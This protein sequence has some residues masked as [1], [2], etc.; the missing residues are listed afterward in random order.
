[1]TGQLEGSPPEWLFLA[2]DPEIDRSGGDPVPGLVE[3]ILPTLNWRAHIAILHAERQAGGDRIHGILKKVAGHLREHRYTS[4]TVHPH[5][6]SNAGTGAAEAFPDELR[7]LVQPFREEAYREQSEPRLRVLP[8]LVPTSTAGSG[9]PVH[10]RASHV[11]ETVLSRVEGDP[12]GLLNPCRRHIVLDEKRG[13]LHSCLDAWLKGE[14]GAAD[15]ETLSPPAAGRCAG[16][17]RSSVLAMKDALSKGGRSREVRR[18]CFELGVALSRRGDHGKA[19]SLARGAFQLSRDDR[20]RTAALIHQGLCHL[21]L[22]ELRQAEEVLREADTRAEDPGA[23]AYHRGRVQFAWKDWIEAL[24]RFEEALAAPS[25]EVPVHDIH[26]HMA[27]CH[28]NLEEY[29]EARPHLDLAGD[30]SLE[31][32]VAFYRAICDLNDGRIQEALNGFVEA[33]R[34]GPADEDLGRIHFYIATCHKEAGRFDEAI[35]ELVQAVEADPDDLANHNLLGY[36]YYST[37]RHMEAVDCFR[38]AVE[39]DPS[40]AIDWANL[41]S[42]LRDLGRVEEAMEMYRRALSLDPTIGFAWQGLRKLQEP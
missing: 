13:R 37:R 23:I 20:E 38:R 6:R 34:I 9:D 40:S 41:G 17:I 18:A 26:F 19:I 15:L 22:G 5:V 36:C 32:P 31:A 27:L 21:A 11:V 35:A 2:L 10:L 7:A 12:G 4:I 33:L 42:N 3:A 8:V 16:C 28:I 30:R 29:A 24:E 39:I 14:R 25:A 1:M